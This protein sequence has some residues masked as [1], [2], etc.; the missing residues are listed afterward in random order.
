M[1]SSPVH[2]PPLAENQELSR[3][4]ERQIVLASTLGTL[5]EWYDFFIY[6]SL[7]VFMSAIIFPP[8]NPMVSLLGALAALAVGFVI[9]PLGGAIFGYLG[10]RFGRKYMFLVTV[11]MM[12]ASTVLLG[13]LP[14]YSAAGN[15]SWILLLVLRVIQGLAVGGEYGGAVVYI[16]EHCSPKRRGLLTSWLQSTCM[17]GLLA[18][19]VV[20]VLCRTAIGPD[21]FKA[22]GWRVPFLASIVLLSISVYIRARLHESPVFSRMKSQGRLSK[23]PLREALSQWSNLKLILIAL[24]SIN[25]GTVA[26][27]YTGQFYVVIFLQ[28][29]VAVDQSLV[30][31]L[32]SIAFLIGVPTYVFLGWLSDRIGRKWIMIAGIFLTALTFRPMFESLISA[33]NPALVEATIAKPVTL[34]ASTNSEDC[35]FS[36]GAALLSSHPDNKKAC[37]KAKQYLVQHGVNFTYVP[38]VNGL[39]VAMSVNGQTISGFDAKAYGA[40]LQSAGYPEKADPARINRTKILLILI[41]MTVIAAMTYASLAAYLVELFPARIRY[42]AISFPYHIGAGIFGGLLPFIATY[43]TLSVGDVLAGLWYPIGLSVI[44]GIVGTIFLPSGPRTS[45][46]TS[47]ADANTP[48]AQ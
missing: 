34:H 16:S 5:F 27:F 31:N 4:E 37:V 47:A 48:T 25:A 28:Q 33:G 21:A 45:A 41:A 44:C 32:L 42:T 36:L 43:L 46:A 8:D 35:S 15:L 13:C 40:A 30:Y 17:L 19:T 38:P 23:N 24:F 9:R 2:L 26:S 18:C 10:D 22:W 3:T 29:A 39:P 12:G 1:N 7:A 6:G 11:V 20:I 14:S